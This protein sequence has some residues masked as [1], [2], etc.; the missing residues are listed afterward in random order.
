MNTIAAVT[1]GQSPRDDVVAELAAYVPGVS[2]IQAGALDGLSES[3]IASLAP[4]EQEVPLVTRLRDGRTVVVG[5]RSLTPYLQAA[6]G[7]VD[8]D[9]TAVVV[10]C[11][12]KLEVY[13]R[14]P[15]VL[16]GLL[17]EAVVR[18]LG[19]TPVAVLT[20]LA[21]QLPAQRARWRAI[22]PGNTV[23]CASP[24]GDTD[25]EAIGRQ[26]SFSGASAVVMDCIGYTTA[27]R[28]QVARASGRPT[29][30]VRSLAAR[31][32]AELVEST[33]A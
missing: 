1:I 5:E 7:R 33:P 15:I 20:P 24:Y 16:P 13:A 21:E 29:L 3:T 32:A 30:L 9:A 31:A 14:A 23:L 11:S 19:I 6:I 18:T 26:A 27:M 4:R 25:F 17:V 2:W 28:A 10:L 12:G 22:H 8:R